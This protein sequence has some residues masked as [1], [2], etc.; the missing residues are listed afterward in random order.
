VTNGQSLL[1]RPGPTKS[2]RANDDDNDVWKHIFNVCKQDGF[3][4]KSDRMWQFDILFITTT[5]SNAADLISG[6]KQGRKFVQ[7]QHWLQCCKNEYLYCQYTR[8][9]QKN[10]TFAIKTLLFVLQHFKQCPLQS[11]L[12][13]WRTPFPTFLPLLEY[14][15]EHPFCDGAHSLIA[16]SWIS[17]VVWQCHFKVVLNLGNRKR[18][19]G[20]KSGD[21]GGWGT[22]DV[23]YFAR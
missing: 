10:R 16:F 20:A 23:W 4:T 9:V 7:L 11:S 5:S 12:L 17:S 14:F 6:G 8:R 3:W 15:L 18:S 13:Y 19:A 21:Q 22:T 2:C 1:R